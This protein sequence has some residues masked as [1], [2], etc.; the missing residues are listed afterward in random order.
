[1][2]RIEL[3]TLICERIQEAD[4]AK[5]EEILWYLDPNCEE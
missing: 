3:I 2:E 4:M 5:L 1:M